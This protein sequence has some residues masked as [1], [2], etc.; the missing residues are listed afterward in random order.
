VSSPLELLPNTYRAFFSGFP[1]LTEAQKRLIQPILKGEDVVLQA[2]TGTGKTEAV[3]A[4]A[5]ENLMTHP[6][7]F[8]IVYIVPT[9]ALALDMNRRIKPIYKK[10]GL[11][12][13]IR[14]GDGK[15]LR[16][17]KPHLLIMTP[18]SLDVLLGSPNQSNKYFLK[19]V[20]LLIIDEVHMFM[21]DDRG[22]QLAYLRRRLAMQSKGQLQTVALSATINDAEE[23]IQFFNLSRTA[24]Y[25]KQSVARKLQPRWVHIED[26]ERELV[27]FFD[28]LHLRSG[29]QKLLVFANSRKKCEHLYNLL[30][31]KGIFSQKV[32][33]HYSNLSTQERKYIESCFRNRKI[34]VCISTSTLEMGIDIGDVDG[35]VLMGPPPSTAAFLQRIGRGNRR[36]QHIDFWGICYGLKAGM[37]LVR[38]LALFELAKANLM[39][40][41]LYAENY[42]VLF[43]QVLSC[44]Y[45]KK[46]VS[47]NALCLLFKDKSEELASIFHH[48]L[49]QN[50]LKPTQQPELYEGG[51]RYVV[52]LKKQQIWSNFPP[53]DEEYAVI[54]EQEKIAVLPLSMVRQLEVG[55]LIQ[56]TGKVLKIL[57]IEEKKAAL[58]VWVEESDQAVHKELVWSGF[59]SPT[60][61]EVAQKMGL[62]LLE[63]AIPE[64]LLNRTRRLLAAE[65]GRIA[66]S[67]EQP[68]GIRVYRLSNG[69]YR[70]ETFLGSV[71]NYILCHLFETQFSS[72]I[73]GLSVHCDEIGLECNEW[74]PFP[75]L[76]IPHTA[77]QFR[78][79]LSAHLPML[80]GGFSWN[81]WIHWLPQELQ[82]KEMIGRLYDPRLLTYFQN[83]HA[84][85]LWLPL[86]ETA[87]NGKKGGVGQITLQGQPWSL[88]REK[89]AWGLL[90]FS[91]HSAN[92]QDAPCSLNATQLQGYVMQKLCPRWARFQHL[93]YQIEAHPRFDEENQKN[94]SRREQGIAFKKHVLEILKN[95]ERVC[96]ETAAF[97]WQQAIRTVACD[98]KPLFLAEAYFSVEASMTGSPD[99]IYIQHQ[100]SHICLEIWDI[101]FSP[102]IHYAHK[103]KVAFYAHLLDRLL[104]EEFFAL[105]IQVSPLGGLLYPS[106][107]ME[108]PF[109]KHP[110]VLAP[111]R[112][113]IGRLLAQWSKDSGRDSAVQDYSMEFSCTSCRYFSYCYQETL[114]KDSTSLENRTLITQNTISNDFPHNSHHWYFIHY[115]KEH[116]QWQ[117]WEKGVSIQ[118]VCLRS[119]DFSSEEAFRQEVARHLQKEWMRSVSQRKNPHLLVY[120]ATDWHLLQKNFESTPLKSL[121]ALHTCWTAVQT[122]LEKH[123]IW[124]IHGRM[125]A[126]QVAACLGFSFIQTP[127]LSLYHREPFEDSSF[128]LYRRIWNWCL[129]HVKSNRE[130]LFENDPAPSVPFIHAYLAMHHRESECRLADMLDFQKN[131]FSERAQQFRS[132]G[133]MRFLGFGKDRKCFQFS[134]DQK[135][136]TSK[137]RVGDFLKLSP[138]DSS[139]I[140]DGFSVVLETYDPGEGVVVVR[141]LT[142]KVNLSRNQ[143]YALDEDATDW[144]GPKITQVLNLLKDPKFRSDL[145]RMLLAGAAK[146]STDAT[147]WIEKWYGSKALAAGLNAMQQKALALPF[148]ERIGLIEG[149]PGTGKTHVLVWTLIALVAHAQSCNRPI[150]ILV[151][152]QTHRAID[153]ILKKVAKTLPAADVSS[154]S[155]WKYR[156]FEDLQFSKLGIDQMQDA[157]TL[158]QHASLILGATGF[159]VYQLLENK[160]FPQLF[161]WVVF[162]ESS[163]VL[164]PYA[165]LSLIFGKGGAL[166]YGDT[167]QL[168]PVLKGN[169]AS[170]SFVPRSILEELISRYGAQN[171]LRLNETY[172]MNADICTF[173]SAHWYESELQ[174]V[175]AKKDQKLELRHYPLF[176]DLC[177]D[178]LDPSRS[179]VVV[180]LE[181][182]GSLQSSQEEA[183]WIAQA[184]K[185]LIENYAVSPEEIGII[186]PHRLQNNTITAA[187]KKALPFSLK[188]PRVD[189]VERMQG[190]EFDLVIFSAAV[191]DKET[192][193]STFLKGYRRLN[194]ALTRARKKFIFVA[195]SLFF[196]SFPTTEKELIA[197]MPFEDLVKWSK[198]VNEPEPVLYGL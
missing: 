51:W 44:L 1:S 82:E 119:R 94:S 121:W 49:T 69:T 81:S 186:S 73:E 149:P 155:L 42:S 22:H 124:P 56:L 173:A 84:E 63:E 43:Q 9:R 108:K 122:V 148:R 52:S 46:Q 152:A 176:R 138:I 88:E 40:K 113:W 106:I 92:R 32:F 132:I 35:V 143:V 107:Q 28:D 197:Q 57:Q 34:G 120:E 127:P 77:A 59:G 31:Q 115:D 193:H 163:Q 191:S 75:S 21:Q 66:Q 64:G 79:W 10:L 20:H 126:V 41:S 182:A 166:F 190:A 65:R 158:Q 5:T 99:L 86:P 67:L 85:S 137:F 72:K 110:F 192:I 90:S 157:A 177:D 179:I 39:E 6:G 87:D 36:Q 80:K 178:Y 168:S 142:Q 98:K 171:R 167:Q 189:T 17:G 144:N 114:L 68:N 162:D 60:S 130:V 2:S 25:Y 180:Q 16:D 183:D 184:V 169:Y 123:F 118:H 187:L 125:T 156:R 13:G 62:I 61:F 89:Q 154:V 11:K 83:Y 93:D 159:G 47:K 76:K 58:E 96:F 45:A 136:P 147:D 53:T 134:I 116:V 50:W 165:L 195:S 30:N 7:H 153:Q 133:P 140:Q 19:H 70:Y 117:C 112:T 38:F 101:T 4:P 185:R 131:P 18:E 14:T 129:S 78:E 150:K 188:L 109:E 172:R 100:G 37:Q 151:T 91:A 55:D 3:L 27:L 29:C 26:E 111:Y 97:T 24:F 160:N 181:H 95:K 194:V 196:H 161:D 48:M 12:S 33:L 141:P 175:A 198:V 54:L 104:K 139:H 71:A 105:P 8:T 146:S 103:W 135:S 145:I 74:L 102:S 15:E 170:T 164:T 174:S 23:I 128:D